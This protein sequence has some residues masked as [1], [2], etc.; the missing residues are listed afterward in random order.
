MKREQCRNI[1]TQKAAIAL[2]LASFPGFPAKPSLYAGEFCACGQL[3]AWKA[4]SET[5]REV[6]V[7]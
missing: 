5:S 4:W 3:C 7:G 2:E 6:D 1:L